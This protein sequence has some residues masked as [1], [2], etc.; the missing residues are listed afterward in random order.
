VWTLAQVAPGLLHGLYIV[1]HGHLTPGGGFQGG[2]VLAGVL[3]PLG[4]GRGEGLPCV[5]QA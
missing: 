5:P 3:V 1:V 2:V 4:E